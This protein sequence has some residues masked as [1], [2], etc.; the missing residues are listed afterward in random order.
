[1]YLDWSIVVQNNPQLCPYG[2]Y[3]EQLSGTAFTAPRET[4]KRTW[5]YRIRPSV[6]HVPFQRLPASNLTNNF[7]SWPPN[8]NQV[9]YA[10]DFLLL[11]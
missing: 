10:E 2:L 5:L 7:N 4:N 8:P 1:M 6:V 11:W 3:C 9:H